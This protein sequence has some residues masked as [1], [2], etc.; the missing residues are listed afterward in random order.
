MKI[1][2]SSSFFPLSVDS[3]QKPLFWLF[4]QFILRQVKNL[5]NMYI[6][7]EFSWEAVTE[8]A[9]MHRSLVMQA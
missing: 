6:F 4:S 9:T 2:Q 5:A 1:S 7:M 3:L 8:V